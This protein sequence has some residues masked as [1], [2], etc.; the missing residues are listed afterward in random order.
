MTGEAVYSVGFDLG[1]KAHE[2]VVTDPD[3]ER[4]HRFAMGRGRHGFD[5]LQQEMA[6]FLP[7][8]SRAVYVVEA[9][10][11]FWQEVVHPLHSAGE[12][13]YLV[14]PTKCADFRKF[15]HRYVK[16][17]PIDAL[18]TSRLP[19][20]DPQLRPV[21]VGSAEQESLRRL[22]RLS[23]KLTE[24]IC[25]HK[26]RLSTLLEML[27]PGVTQVW[28]NHYCG[29]ARLFY[30]RYL[31]PARARRLGQKRLAAVLRRRAWGKFSAQAEQ[32]LWA[33]IQNA[34]TLRYRADDLSLEVNSE[35]D[36]LEALEKRQVAL[37][38][39]IDELYSE[40]DP[41]RH[42]EQV[43]GL[44]FFFAAALTAAI[45][46]P[47]R[48]QNADQVVAAAGLVPRKR[49]SSG[50]EKA[51][52]PITKKGNPQ[53]RCWLY[54][55][56][57]ITRHYDPELQAFFRRLRRRG[58]HHKAAI[59]AVAAKLLR[60]LYAVLRDGSRYRR[61]AEDTIEQEKKPVRASVHEVATRLLKDEPAP[62]S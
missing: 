34:P 30:R 16:T 23:W 18:A 55:A 19:R 52:Q 41:S 50:K 15:F 27:L 24:Q 56:A 25:D 26:R 44:G 35:L 1:G 47:Q 8:A 32:K 62:A 13:V 37:R 40:V 6:A 38:E 60:R 14:D 17:D 57:E 54:V 2:V 42:L 46:D 39:R 58:L 10:Q 29:S 53:L 36:L 12:E 9:A 49:A 4:V 21:W 48:W 31:D 22:C 43:P 33:V 61:L 28:R 3:G 11:N 45:G 20:T 7:S 51:H 5:Q 59:C